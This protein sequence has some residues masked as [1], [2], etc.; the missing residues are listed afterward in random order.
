MIC[1][2]AENLYQL[3]R[4]ID[5]AWAWGE[6]LEE[7][8]LD[9]LLTAHPGRVFRPSPGKSAATLP[10]PCPG[11]LESLERRY[12]AYGE[13]FRYVK[14]RKTLKVVFRQ[15]PR[16]RFRPAT[17]E[18]APSRAVYELRDAT[19][20][21]AFAP[22][23]LTRVSAL[24][25]RLRDGA[26]ERL[27]QALPKRS[28]EIDRV[29]VGRKPDGTNDGPAEDRVRIMP[30]PSIGH[31]H[32]D[33]EV[34]RVLV[35]VPPT[36]PLPVPDVHWAFSGLH[37]ADAE[38]GEIQAVLTRTEDNALLRQY[39][40]EEDRGHP[41]W[42]TVTPA[43]L[44]EDARRRRI[45]PARKREEAKA[46]DERAREQARAAVA[47]SQALRH[48]GVGAN[49]EAIHVQREPFEGN[50]AR[51]EPFA[52]GTRFAKERLWHVEI[53][54]VEPVTGPL[55]IGDGRFLGLGLMAP[56]RKVQGVHV[57]AI[58]AGT[59]D[60]FEEAD[61]VRA[62]RRAVMARVQA[63]IGPSETPSPFYSGHEL[64]GPPAKSEQHSHL[65]FAFDRDGSRLLVIAPHV[66]DRRPARPD[67]ERHLETLERALTG[68][69][70]LRAGTAG[71]LRIRPTTVQLD[72][73]PLFAASRNWESVTPYRVTRHP[74]GVTAEEALAIDLRAECQRR[75]LPVP[76][77][78]T[79]D[80][81]SLPGVGLEGR[82]RLHFN[83][84]VEGPLLL[85]KSR[86]K[87][88]GLFRGSS[89]VL[90]QK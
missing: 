41:A 32:A 29:L 2:L 68:M 49:V 14:D 74:R 55:V 26:V 21:A 79:S 69:S 58:E 61:V 15:P 70:E 25:V 48:A 64:D 78:V 75:G 53:R 71:L 38:T 84:V 8:R 66:V 60:N 40:L 31:V 73:D 34:R 46:G 1:S 39:G 6:L 22:W 50:G 36:C 45:D 11:S 18:S 65:A 35:E 80:C 4:G 85:G 67:E 28:A 54:F 59:G 10:S 7:Q 86:Y 52:V 24:V 81:H 30:L 51:A 88:G 33:H 77:V 17:Y 42:R 12:R 82:V 13:R 43:A 89:S 87:G 63:T 23:P 44:P 3:G 47:V 56:L 72:T 19:A 57:F 62:W 5:M 76:R 20:E 37:V 90:S 16:P 27:K 9:E 83:V